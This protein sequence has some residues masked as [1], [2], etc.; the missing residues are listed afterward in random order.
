MYSRPWLD[1]YDPGVPHHLDY[2]GRPL[3]SLLDDAA[4][5][6]P[7]RAAVAFAGASW[8]YAE[9]KEKAG[10]GA[11]GLRKL[12]VRPGDRVGIMLPN[13]P[14]TLAA[15]WAVLKAGAVAVMVNPLY[16]EYE[17]THQLNDAGLQTLIV[18]DLALPKVWPLRE[19][20][21]VRRYVVCRL[22]DNLPWPKRLAYRVKNWR[23]GPKLPQH[24]MV[25][26]WPQMAA[27]GGEFQ[28]P[29]LRGRDVALLQYT[30][31][32][33]G[34]AKGCMLT[35]DNLM[36]NAAQCAAILHAIGTCH[37]RFL[38]IMP[39]F[40]IYGMTVG[41]LFPTAIGATILPLPRFVPSDTLSAI[42]GLK[43]TIFPGAP[44]L[45]LTLMRQKRFAAMDTSSL[46]F[47]ISGSSPMPKAALVEFERQSGA[48][49]LEGYGLTEAGPV[50]HLNPIAGERRV[51]SIGMPF[52]DTD[53]KVVELDGNGTEVPPG[54]RGELWVKGPQVMA[55]Y[56]NRPEAT[57]AVLPDGWLQTGD[58][59][60]MDQDGYFAIV[61]RQKDLIITSGYNVYP[62]E[63]EE[64][65]YT[66]PKVAEVA[67]VGAPHPTRGEVVRAYVVPVEGQVPTRAEL[68]AFCRAQLADYKVP[69]QVELVKELPK[70]ALG[71]VL[72]RKLQEK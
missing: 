12:G 43:P 63:V 23:K 69:R 39:F 48:T 61:D 17:L 16:G 51:G 11:A 3:H 65:L 29:D 2:S 21:P 57:A 62:R 54:Q 47:C 52:P 7:D 72:R 20:L 24:S 49:I 36:A 5:R 25:V 59:A 64:V 9:L 14:Q 60:V 27:S 67:C 26:E 8:S 33:T 38:G 10:R 28:H 66:H 44:T 18:L 4:E 22:Q 46:R 42:E 15:F 71:K 55:G 58:V 35:H 37:E 40:H 56:W 53:A 31:G 68:A 34:Q 45:Y 1:R 13:L 50:T 32:T 70:S 41:L 6:Y 19:K 30:G